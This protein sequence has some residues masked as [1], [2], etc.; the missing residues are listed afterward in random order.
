MRLGPARAVRLLVLA[1]AVDALLTAAEGHHATVHRYYRLKARLLRLKT[2]RGFLQ[3]PIRKIL[4]VG[5]QL[6][7]TFVRRPRR[8]RRSSAGG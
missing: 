7:R 5:V 6:L 4:S 1:V 3:C 2:R 8:T